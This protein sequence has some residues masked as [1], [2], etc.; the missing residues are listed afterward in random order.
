MRRSVTFAVA[1]VALA[2]I[3]RPAAAAFSTGCCACIESH[4]AQTS[5]LPSETQAL[6]CELITGTGYPAF[7]NR[8][9]TLGGN[10]APCLNPTPGVSCTA[11]LAGEGIACPGA[12]S[13]P[14]AGVWGLTTV[15]MLLAVLGIRAAHR[16]RR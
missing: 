15:A 2:G 6:A 3:A 13:V 10:S 8:C 5:Q 4:T 14:A 11:T 16:R 1:L 9:E 7:V 12:S